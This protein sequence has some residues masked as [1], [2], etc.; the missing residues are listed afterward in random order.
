MPRTRHG[1]HGPG[2]WHSRQSPRIRRLFLFRATAK[3]LREGPIG[4]ILEGAVVKLEPGMLITSNVRLERPL[5]E[6]GMG[7]VWLAEHLSL[8]SR[9][10]VKFIADAYASNAEAKARFSREAAAASQVKSPHVV[11]TFDHGISPEGVPYIV[12]ELLE[13]R[14]LGDTLADLGQLPPALVAE[15]VAQL[16]RALEKAHA[17]GII[18]RDIKPD[19]VF[20]CD[21]GDGAVF[22]KLLD[23]GIAKGAAMTNIGKETKTGS[24]MGSP[25]YMSP[26]Q[27]IGA[28]NIDHRA[29][30]WAVG[31]VAYEALVGVRPF[32]AETVG[33]LTMKIHNDPLPLPCTQRPDLP[34]A[35]DAWFERACALSPE[36]RFASAKELADAL[37]VALLGTSSRST[38]APSFSGI[39]PQ[40]SQPAPMS[41][42]LTTGDLDPT[43]LAP[44][45]SRKGLYVG[46]GLAI[47]L[48]GL[49]GGGVAMYGRSSGAQ[50][51]P[52]PP[53]PSTSA[54]AA[55]TGAPVA[56]PLALATGSA[57]APATALPTHAVGVAATVG[58]SPKPPIKPGATAS[59]SAPASPATSAHPVKP[60]E[61]EILR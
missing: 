52:E 15:I 33:A 14:S 13:G 26:E 7:S 31:V 25:L 36:A 49:V 11:Q 39:K 17:A 46:V 38:V 23:F 59:A 53:L 40:A 48:L 43:T 51:V 29:D 16:C 35:V 18:H 47:V 4:A 1:D 22:V 3:K 5:G 42:T 28:K 20:L 61:D 34:P 10:V 8:H 19:N 6:G 57:S 55:S 37:A 32:D 41:R 21:A 27:L 60:P 54:K 44:P 56:D 30:L 2:L 9:V 50:A 24:V 58:K 12:M 45:P